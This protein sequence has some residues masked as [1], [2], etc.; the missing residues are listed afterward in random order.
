MMTTV[1]MVVIVVV[2]VIVVIVVV[3]VI[4]VVVVAVLLTVP[5]VCLVRVSRW[6]ELN[7]QEVYLRYLNQFTFINQKHFY[8]DDKARYFWK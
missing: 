5:K 6:L 4:V 8:Q 3:M 1:V 7:L 2:V